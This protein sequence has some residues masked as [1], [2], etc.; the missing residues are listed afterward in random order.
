MNR[1]TST[2]MNLT[3]QR[4]NKDLASNC[5]N[6]TLLLRYQTLLQDLNLEEW[7]KCVVHLQKKTNLINLKSFL[8][9]QQTVNLTNCWL[10]LTKVHTSFQ[11]A[12]QSKGNSSNLRW[13][14]LWLRL[15]MNYQISSR[16]TTTSSE[17]HSHAKWNLKF[18]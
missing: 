2:L 4:R 11:K 14:T 17:S 5:L 6:K 8:M 9:R 15:I 18:P 16:F 3:L 10:R 7:S 13:E 12:L 1:K